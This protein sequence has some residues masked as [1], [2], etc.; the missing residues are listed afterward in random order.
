M[1]RFGVLPLIAVCTAWPAIGAAPP[2]SVATQQG[3][4]VRQS[5]EASYFTSLFS[6][7]P[8]FIGDDFLLSPDGRKFAFLT[9]KGVIATDEIKSTIWIVDVGSVRNYLAHPRRSVRPVPVEI[10]TIADK[11]GGGG[12]EDMGRAI[13]TLRW[14]PD[15]QS[16][17]FRAM[18]QA[19]GHALCTV[20]LPSRRIVVRSLPNQD[21][22]SLDWG[23]PTIAYLATPTQNLSTLRESVG[24]TIPD[25]EIG[26][27][28]SLIDLLYP[29]YG[30]AIEAAPQAE[31]WTIRDGTDAAPVVDK[32]NG[33]KRVI[34]YQSV[35]LSDFP[36][37]SVSPDGRK[38][39]VTDYAKHIPRSWERYARGNGNY[40]L[41]E[42]AFVADADDENA[43]KPASRSDAG[44]RARQFTVIDVFS[45][46]QKPLLDAPIADFRRGWNSTYERSVWSPDGKTIALGSTYLPIPTAPNAVDDLI[47]CLVTTVSIG[48]HARCVKHFETAKQRTSDDPHLI[49]ASWSGKAIKLTYK[50]GTDYGHMAAGESYVVQ[51]GSW[52]SRQSCD[53]QPDF[54]VEQSLDSWPILAA[55]DCVGRRAAILNPNS[56]FSG[57]DIGKTTLLE[58]RDKLGRKQIGGLLTPP[59]FDPRRKYPLVI[60]T[61]GFDPES[62][63]RTGGYETGQAA[64]ALVGRGII[65]LQVDEPAYITA[66]PTETEAAE[67]VYLSALDS[68]IQRGFI[69]PKRVG[70]TAFSRT[71]PYVGRTITDAADRFAA[72]AFSNTDAGSYWDYLAY[73]DY[74]GPSTIADYVQLEAQ[75]MP[76]TKDGLQQWIKVVPG[77]RA[78]RIRAATLFTAGDQLHLLFLWGLYAPMRAAGKTVELQYMRT[79]QHNLTF[80]SQRFA[81]QTLLVDWFDFWLN[82]HQDDDPAKQDLY[83]RWRALRPDKAK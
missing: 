7:T 3:L 24:P 52:V 46:E 57:V 60:Q 54:Y 67:D 51:G 41:M 42:K 29:K 78:D 63:I 11:T 26:T 66:T 62:F 12:L 44:S 9:H 48:G 8:R 47:P 34:P 10:V 73:V 65:V 59:G 15:S 79:G 36:A 77:F 23:G 14:S 21:V 35:G 19:G 39:V 2:P 81:A 53:Q 50:R 74:G 58:W 18:G 75:G 31:L 38:I 33:T 13:S 82:D 32:S 5:V 27:G 61:H 17:A 72:A 69:D 20:N 1:R 45:G 4:T 76:P 40:A 25:I 83:A 37:V 28:K 64:R 80:P 6:S 22:Q 70:I 30:D 43:S 56:S 68:L 55:K 71:G 49:G 16:L